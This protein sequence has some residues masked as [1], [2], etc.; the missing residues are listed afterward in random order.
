M[1][2]KARL[3][4]VQPRTEGLHEDAT[5]FSLA[6]FGVDATV[7]PGPGSTLTIGLGP[8]AFALR[9]ECPQPTRT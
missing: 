5:G 9:H 3:A 2:Q 6:G 7:I 1:I 8:P 4:P